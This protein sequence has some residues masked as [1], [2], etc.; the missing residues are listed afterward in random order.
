MMYENARQ[1]TAKRE[2]K[3]TE[4]TAIA[5]PTIEKA[6]LG[7]IAGDTIGSVYE[8]DNIKTT[9]FPLFIKQ[10]KFTDDSVMTLA[11]AKALV[12]SYDGTTFSKSKLVDAMQD[13]GKRH[14]FAGYGRMFYKW[15]HDKAPEPYNSYG[16][17]SAMRVSPVAWVTDDVKHAEELAKLSAEVTHNHPEGIKGAQVTAGCIVM[18]RQG[19]SNDEIR[20]YVEGFGYDLGFT[21]DEIRPTYTFNETCQGSVPQA[22]EAFLEATDFESTVRLCVSI[23]GDCDTTAAIAGSIAHARWGI[24][25]TIASNT[26]RRLTKGLIH[27]LDEFCEKFDVR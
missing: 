3:E 13:I 25:S 20:R 22:I 24:P 12:D 19:A 1:T 15:L 16:N 8:F 10:S 17:G 7:A 4:M 11:V 18:A 27:T 6:M 26:R 2:R 23:G 9:E 14:R 21:L 5:N